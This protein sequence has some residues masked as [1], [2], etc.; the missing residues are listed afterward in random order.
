M[1]QCK[2][3]KLCAGRCF[4]GFDGF[5]MIP[6]IERTSVYLQSVFESNNVGVSV[7]GNVSTPDEL[8]GGHLQSLRQVALMLHR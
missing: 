6:A 5:A 8:I 4:D 2:D 1:V 3:G 7:Y